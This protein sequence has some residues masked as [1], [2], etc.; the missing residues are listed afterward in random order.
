MQTNEIGAAGAVCVSGRLQAILHRNR[1][2]RTGW[3]AG[4]ESAGMNGGVDE[5]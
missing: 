3:V 4:W 2:W 1:Q 5:W